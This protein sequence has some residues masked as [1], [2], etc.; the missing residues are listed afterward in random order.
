MQHPLLLALLVIAL[1]LFAAFYFVS[2]AFYYKRHQTKFHFYQMFP[3]EYNYPNVFK[4]NFYGNIIFAFACLSVIAFYVINP[5]QSI[6]SL[7][8]IILAIVLTMMYLT[9]LL[10]PLRYLRAHMFISCIAM[11]LSAALPVVNLFGALNEMKLVVD[12]VNKILCIVSMVISG[13]LGLMM[14]LLIMNPKLTFK[15]YYEKEIDSEGNEIK[16]RPKVILLALNEWWAIFTFFLT[17]IAL[18]LLFII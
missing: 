4:E 12:D 18:I 3:Y 13:L 15:I 8:G 6:Y 7:L 11:T 5:M 1:C 17:P 10:L 14:L 2:A 9:V 16:K